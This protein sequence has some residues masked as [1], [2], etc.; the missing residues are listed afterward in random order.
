MI[1]KTDVVI[2]GAGLSGLYAAHLLQQQ[3]KTVSLLE[4]R[5][6][7]GGRLDNHQFNNGDLVDVGGQW[8]GP[9]HDGMYALLKKFGLDFYPLYDKGQHLLWLGKKARRYSGTIPKLNPLALIQLGWL[10]WRFDV[11]ARTLDVNAPWR[12]NKAKQW[13]SLT[14][15]SWIRKNSISKQARE[16][17]RI[18]IGAVFAVEC[19]EIS[20]LHALIYAQSNK[21]LD[22][23]ISVTGGAQ[24]DR[25]HGGS[26]GL[27]QQIADSLGDSLHLNCEVTSIRW[28]DDRVNVKSNGGE[29]EGKKII[30]AMPP[31]QL[32]RLNFSPAL[33]GVKDQLWQ[34]MPAGSC[35][36]C[37]AQ[38][39]TP[40]WRADNLS[41]Q[42]VSLQGDLPIR[43]TF[44]NTES[45]KA[46]GLLM[47]F[48]EGDH[49]RHW[50]EKSEQERKQAVL[51]SFATFFGEQA[52][53]PID[54]V[55]RN[56]A[57]EE[58]S[59]GCYSA[60]PTPGTW[61]S[62]GQHLRTSVGPIHFAGTETAEH[63]TG[64]MEGALNAA[65]RCVKEV[66]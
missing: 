66:T 38:Y 39:A 15:E 51:E 3:G 40:F 29:Y 53:Q 20:L 8:I 50:G 19:S 37:V 33:P 1:I 48:I 65:Q 21:N 45:G 59:R 35:I 62:L 6:R 58:F 46:A 23:L 12:H 32:L 36:K 7:V 42:V 30:L 61:T 60:N 41:G 56:W 22:Y 57:N 49:A 44:D 34:H 52:L 47:G 9:G 4:A 13:D 11:M 14:L 25:I 10:M 5:E 24:Q 43:V 17:F 28:S 63:Y 26:A 54:Y 2:V 55:D 16:L 64:Y 31:N 18:S 27:C